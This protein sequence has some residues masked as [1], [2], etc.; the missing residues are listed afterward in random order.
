MICPK[1]VDLLDEL[2]DLLEV[3]EHDIYIRIRPNLKTIL[4]PVVIPRS[5]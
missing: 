5:L 3:E 1:L 4:K 2:L